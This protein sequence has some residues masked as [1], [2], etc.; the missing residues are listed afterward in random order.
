MKKI[1]ALAVAVGIICLFS[2]PYPIKIKAEPN[3]SGTIP[4]GAMYV[5]LQVMKSYG[6]TGTVGY[7][8]GPAGAQKLLA[9]LESWRVARK[10][11]LSLVWEN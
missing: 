8:R 10:L 5:P 4:W 3:R 9:D 1:I 7:Y 11:K 6:M 2:D